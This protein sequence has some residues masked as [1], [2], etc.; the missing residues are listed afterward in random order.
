[1]YVTGFATTHDDGSQFHYTV[2][3][4]PTVPPAPPQC[5]WGSAGLL[6]NITFP[7]PLIM[8]IRNDLFGEPV[9]VGTQVVSGPPP[10]PPTQTTIGTLQPGECI[11]IPIQ[12]YSGVFANCANATESTVHCLIK[13]SA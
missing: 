4:R 11:S 9:T 1:M 3:V 2:R 8:H 5:L 7:K 12:G 6:E 13:A 10:S